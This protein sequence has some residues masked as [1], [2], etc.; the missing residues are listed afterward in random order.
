MSGKVMGYVFE[1][2]DLSLAEKIVLLAY[3]DNAHHDGT[4]IFPS[5][6]TVALKAS[7]SERTV[8]RCKKSLIEKGYLIK[9]GKHRSGTDLLRIPVPNYEGGDRETP[10]N[11]NRV[12]EGQEGV[13]ESAK[14][15][16]IAVSPDPS[17]T[18]IN[19]DDIKE[20]GGAGFYIF[21]LV[22]F[23][24]G[25]ANGRLRKSI[26]NLVDKYGEEQLCEIAYHIRAQ[27][28]QIDL[29]PFLKEIRERADGFGSIAK[30]EHETVREISY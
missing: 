25:E 18:T 5:V 9:E 8:Q 14:G 24:Y 11:G 15:G 10:P 16:D 28:T 21:N 29:H 20:L 26:N 12:T 19:R 3:A 13:T 6:E 1:I 17:L 22:G 4:S 23:D 27:Y 30:V 2:Q 7:C